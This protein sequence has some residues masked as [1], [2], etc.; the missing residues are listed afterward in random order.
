MIGE[1][2]AEGLV[3]AAYQQIQGERPGKHVPGFLRL[4]SLVPRAIVPLAQ[5][6]RAVTYGP[7]ALARTQRELIAAFVSSLNKCGPCQKLHTSLLLHRLRDEKLVAQVLSDFRTAPLA[8]QDR[9]MLEYAEKLTLAPSS[10]EKHDVDRLRQLGFAEEAIAEIAII[11]ALFNYLNRVI[12]GL[13][14]G[15]DEEN[16]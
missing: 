10:V 8:A 2:E 12:R 11:T 15:A 9:A 1:E 14:L 3:R 4:H 7:G 5:L 16:A 6:H 13:G